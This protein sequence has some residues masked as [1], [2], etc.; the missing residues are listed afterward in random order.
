MKNI[1]QYLKS[2][3]VYSTKEERICWRDRKGYT[4]GYRGRPVSLDELLFII[5]EYLLSS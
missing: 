5:N 2:R 1:E 3:F 4:K